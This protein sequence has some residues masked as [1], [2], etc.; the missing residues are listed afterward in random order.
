[1]TKEVIKMTPKMIQKCSQKYCTHQDPS[2]HCYGARSAQQ[3]SGA[4]GL[5]AGNAFLN[6]HSRD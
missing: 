6:D 5:V 4:T 3:S 2:R 1:M